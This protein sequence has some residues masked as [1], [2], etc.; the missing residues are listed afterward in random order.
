MKTKL[1]KYRNVA[2]IFNPAYRKWTFT[3][4]AG[5]GR[6][7]LITECPGGKDTARKVAVQC[8]ASLARGEGINGPLCKAAIRRITHPVFED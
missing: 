5:N 4:D 2:F 3:N 7:T 1:Y 8:S 6:Q